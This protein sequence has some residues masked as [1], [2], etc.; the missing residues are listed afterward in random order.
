MSVQEAA[1]IALWAAFAVLVYAYVGYPLLMAVLARFFGRHLRQ[2]DPV[3]QRVSILMSV[4][5]EA[6]RIRDRLAELTR[7]LAAATPHGEII[8]VC[9]GCT[10]ATA[11]IANEFHES[12]VRVLEIPE[13]VGKAAAVTRGVATSGADVILLADARQRFDSQTIPSLLSPFADPSVGGVSGELVLEESPGVLAGV[14]AY[15]KY[16]KWLRK[17][18]SKLHSQIG[19]TGAVSAVRRKYF[20]P[21][22]DG[23]ILDDVYWPMQVVAKHRRRVVFQADAKA[24]DQLSEHAGDEF[25]RKVRTLNGNL[26]LVAAAPRLI[27][28]G[29]NPLWGR[30]ISHKLLRLACPW[31]IVLMV[32]AA[33]LAGDAVSLFVLGVISGFALTGALAL[34]TPLGK[35]NRILST[36][37][38]FTMLNM[39]AFLATCYW[40][41]RRESDRLWVTN[42][43]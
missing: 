6:G 19:A 31:A 12:G 43:G 2:S 7:R 33:I 15:W 42:R 26:Q 29:F 36:V 10:D 32:P 24:Y 13:G 39:A 14:G 18:E 8:V 37:G 23:L 27:L 20:E 41:L 16:E 38:S 9:D 11:A 35:A 1:R 21:I 5:N 3:P 25:R 28:L 17:N 22:P 30:F 40:V 34:L 4:R